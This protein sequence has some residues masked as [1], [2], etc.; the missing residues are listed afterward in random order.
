VPAEQASP[1]LRAGQGGQRHPLHEATSSRLSA[2]QLKNGPRVFL[3]S[4]CPARPL[5]EL[6]RTHQKPQFSISCPLIRQPSSHSGGRRTRNLAMPRPCL[7]QRRK[8]SGAKERTP[9]PPAG[10]PPSPAGESRRHPRPHWTLASWPGVDGQLSHGT[11]ARYS[12]IR[13]PT[14]GSCSISDGS[15]CWTPPRSIPDSDG[16]PAARRPSV[17]DSV[18]LDSRRRRRERWRTLGRRLLAAARFWREGKQSKKRRTGVEDD[19][20]RINR[21]MGILLLFHSFINRHRSTTQKT[22]GPFRAPSLPLLFVTS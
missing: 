10:W 2:P 4:F 12:S 3:D 6:W 11:A 8:G 19:H 13:K 14:C 22:A 7:E 15:R 5:V 9:L 17:L 1:T 21:V 16:A 18:S 20:Y